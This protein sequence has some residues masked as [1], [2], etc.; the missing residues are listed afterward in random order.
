MLLATAVAATVGVA[1]AT[2]VV[3]IAIAVA[4]VIV[5]GVTLLCK[6]QSQQSERSQLADAAVA[7]RAAVDACT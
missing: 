4:L 3:G 5:A 7:S 1:A 6:Y 2:A